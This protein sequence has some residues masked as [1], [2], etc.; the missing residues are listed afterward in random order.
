MTTPKI[1]L[2]KDPSRWRISAM[3]IVLGESRNVLRLSEGTYAPVLYLPKS[4]LNMINFTMTNKSTHC[5]YKGDASYYSVSSGTKTLE[6]IGWCY[7]HPLDSVA[8]IKN[9]I[10]FYTDQINI[11][12]Q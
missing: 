6:N 9:H 7:E 1:T 8:E 11:E 10:A 4:D 5:P 12:K 3:G 2:E